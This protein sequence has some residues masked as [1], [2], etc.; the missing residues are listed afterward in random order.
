[1][2]RNLRLP[3]RFSAALVQANLVASLNLSVGAPTGTGRSR[4]GR[5][6]RRR[7][8]PRQRDDRNSSMAADGDS[9]SSSGT[10]HASS[11]PVYVACAACSHWNARGARTCGFC[12]CEFRIP[13]EEGGVSTPGSND[14]QS[15]NHVDAVES[16][17]RGPTRDQWYDI[18]RIA[19]RRESSH[20]S[21]PECPIC[22]DSFLHHDD[23]GYVG[24]Q[25]DSKRYDAGV[26]RDP[27]RQQQ[28]QA[29]LSCSHIFH[30]SCLDSYERHLGWA[31]RA[32]P[33]CR[34]RHYSRVPTQVGTQVHR[35]IC[36]TRIVTA[37]RGWIGRKR[38]RRAFLRECRT[39]VGGRNST[40][41]RVT[42]SGGEDAVS[43]WERCVQ[44]EEV[45]DVTR[46]IECRF[47]KDEDELDFLC[48][49]LDRTIRL[50]K[51]ANKVWDLHTN[52]RKSSFS[53]K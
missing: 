38:G 53:T 32:C 21:V 12:G 41:E 39:R 51:S 10:G 44:I 25:F 49:A 15:S 42:S 50:S 13:T 33:I 30:L 8:R 48:A 11:W 37:V 5:R 28:V 6:I 20:R 35:A 26:N 40:R 19:F 17:V 18:E 14:D 3:S 43:Q 52:Q 24:C 1:M 27:A 31:N 36:A 2:P 9:N 4:D 16:D 46:H 23:A 22:H 7:Q 34:V 45:K 29:L 47:G